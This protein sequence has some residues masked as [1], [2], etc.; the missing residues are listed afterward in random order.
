MGGPKNPMLNIKNLSHV[1]VAKKMAL[2]HVTID[3]DHHVTC[4]IYEIAL[5][6]VTKVVMS[7]VKYKKYSCRRVHFKKRPCCTV[8]FRGLDPYCRIKNYYFDEQ[9]Y[10]KAPGSPLSQYLHYERR[11]NSL[12]LTINRS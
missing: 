2:S 1:T 7:H 11:Q 5:S 12:P 9:I 4:R 3:F 8:D 10:V 6:H